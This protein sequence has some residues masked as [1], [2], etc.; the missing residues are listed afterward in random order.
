[1]CCQCYNVAPIK[2]QAFSEV[3]F[4]IESAKEEMRCSRM[5]SKKQVLHVLVFFRL[6]Q[7]TSVIGAAQKVLDQV[8]GF[9]QRVRIS[10]QDPHLAL[11]RIIDLYNE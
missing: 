2:L 5:P 9:W 8:L 3:L 4:L 7:N 11:K 6:C 10:T 1:M